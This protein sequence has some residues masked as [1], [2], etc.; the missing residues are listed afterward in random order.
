MARTAR[1]P[2]ERVTVAELVGR[3][4]TAP[5]RRPRRVDRPDHLASGTTSA[6]GAGPPEDCT[7]AGGTG[8]ERALGT[9]PPENAALPDD[10]APLPV[11]VA[12]E[13]ARRRD[14]GPL[15]WTL[16][17]GAGAVVVLGVLGAVVLGSSGRQVDG[18]PLVGQPSPPVVTVP[19]ADSTASAG[20]TPAE[21]AEPAEP[22]PAARQEVPAGT[23]ER[24]PHAPAREAEDRMREA[25][26][27]REAIEPMLEEMERRMREEMPALPPMPRPPGW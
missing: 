13:P 11:V 4:R 10:T 18:A 6:G 25:R 3:A 2:A 5:L 27:A 16:L 15:A 20:E 8:G 26:E 14:S 21:S 22:P 23:P 19:G 7:G 1:N 9:R 17:S 12:P 24:R